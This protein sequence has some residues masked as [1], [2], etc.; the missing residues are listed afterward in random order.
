MP[1]Q[2]SPSDWLSVGGL[3][4]GAQSKKPR[5]VRGSRLAHVTMSKLVQVILAERG[6]FEHLIRAERKNIFEFSGGDSGIRTP[7]LRIMI[8]SL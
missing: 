3:K 1:P 7:D 8:P 4:S 2:P 6:G 5:V